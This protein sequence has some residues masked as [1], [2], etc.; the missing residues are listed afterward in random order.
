MRCKLG[1][2]AFIKKSIRTENIGLI[3]SCKENLGYHL[4]GD[5]VE[6]NKE[7]FMSPDSDNI[8]II[9]SSSGSIETQFGKSKIGYIPDTWLEPIEPI[10]DEDLIDEKELDEC[11]EDML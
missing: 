7:R 9:E 11:L 6:I 5:I 10:N 4:R 8:W 1:Q 2:L 3:V